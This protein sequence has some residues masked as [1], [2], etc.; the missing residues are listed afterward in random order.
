MYS[1]CE[2]T[3]NLLYLRNPK[4]VSEHAAHMLMLLWSITCSFLLNVHLSFSMISIV[5]GIW[6]MSF[7]TISNL[8]EKFVVQA[9]RNM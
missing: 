9:S 4:K 8:S 1:S 5:M 2:G 6:V 3:V 7:N